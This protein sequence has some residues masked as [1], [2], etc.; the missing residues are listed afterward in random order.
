MEP[1]SIGYSRNA[2]LMLHDT[3]KAPLGH[4]ERQRDLHKE[5][6]RRE[7]GGGSQAGGQMLRAG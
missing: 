1:P 6:R 3:A 4:D 2:A 7:P 5:E